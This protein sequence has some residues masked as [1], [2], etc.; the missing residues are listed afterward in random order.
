VLLILIGEFVVCTVRSEPSVT[1]LAKV[2]APAAV[3]V[4]LVVNVIPEPPAV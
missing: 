4:R 3:L 2:M 1:G